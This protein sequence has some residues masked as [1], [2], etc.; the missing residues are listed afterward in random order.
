VLRLFWK[1]LSRPRCVFKAQSKQME[2][3]FLIGLHNEGRGLLSIQQFGSR[4]RDPTVSG[5]TGMAVS[6]Y[7]R[8]QL[9]MGICL[10]AALITLSILEHLSKSRL[11]LISSRRILRRFLGQT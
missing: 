11:S 2:T 6:V 9:A 4:V 5:S 7:L 10:A 1:P 8:D 3:T